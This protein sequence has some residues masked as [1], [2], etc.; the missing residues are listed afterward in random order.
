MDHWSAFVIKPYCLIFA[1]SKNII[2]S[3]SLVPGLKD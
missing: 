2:H 1:A 3:S